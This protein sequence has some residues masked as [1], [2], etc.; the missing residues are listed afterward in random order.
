MKPMLL[1]IILFS[2]LSL[3]ITA[4]T[5]D[6]N[7]PYTEL[8]TL[9]NRNDPAAMK[10][11]GERLY[12]GD[13]MPKDVVEAISWLEKAAAAGD[14][15]AYYDLSVIYLNNDG[16]TRDVPKAIGYLRKGADLNNVDA[17]TSLAMFC[18]AGERADPS[19]TVDMKEA[20]KWY[21]RAA[22]QNNTD[23]IQR[24]AMI[25]RMGNGVEKS[26]IDAV[27]WFQRGADLGNFDCMWAVG[28]SLYDGVGTKKDIVKGLAYMTIAAENSSDPEQKKAMKDRLAKYT[29]TLKK[30]Q[31]DE[32]KWIVGEWKGKRKK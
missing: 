6:P 25:Y 20:I 31:L 11:L 19:L 18:Q 10:L 32:M 13:T 3:G 17:Q 5:I 26:E 15:E 24:L 27:K 21:S 7:M 22:A 1:C 4:P 23:A 2:S 30:G 28:Q 8:K 9:V 12:R 14:G 29:E 16:V